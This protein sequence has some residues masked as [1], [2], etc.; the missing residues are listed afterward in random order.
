[1]RLVKLYHIDTDT[2]LL[3]RIAKDDEKAFRV[4]YDR[5]WKKLLAHALVKMG[6]R[7]DAEDLVQ[8]VF[9]N[10][11]RRRNSLQVKHTFNT[12]IAAILK[13][14]I[15]RKLAD[16]SRENRTRIDVSSQRTVADNSTEQWLEFTQ[17]QDDLEK[18]VRLLPEKCQLVF[19]LSREKG[20]TERQISDS[21]QIA[22]KTVQAHLGKALKMLRV[23]MQQFLNL[24]IGGLFLA[25]TFF[26]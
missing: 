5:Y 14:E 1:M 26:R 17:L 2:N 4:L 11:W 8:L 20:L 6:D 22:P 15:L 21:L 9:I 18:Y 3:A 19:R 10:L 13:Y 23:S 12:Y 24:V 16:Q 25:A 7:Q